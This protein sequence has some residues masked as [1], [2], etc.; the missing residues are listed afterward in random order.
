MDEA[1]NKRLGEL[2]FELANGNV[3]ALSEIYVIM[4]K[5]LYAIGNIYYEQKADVE[6]AV[7][8]LLLLICYKSKKFK[9]NTNACAWIIKT[10]QNSIK[11]HLRRRKRENDFIE[12]KV[13]VIKSQSVRDDIYL[14]NHLFINDM[15]KR[16][17]S[18]ERDLIIYRYWS[19][20][21]IGEIARILFKPKS[22]IESQLKNLENKIKNL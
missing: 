14:D 15:F 16:L 5:L 17:T 11:N 4:A 9:A 1:T 22:T 3:E 21:S 8:N 19:K 6:D 7:Q 18:Y 13:E 12:N 2:I 10:F 20:C